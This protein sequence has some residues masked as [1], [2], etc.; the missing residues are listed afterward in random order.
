MTTEA[1]ELLKNHAW[2]GNVR[3]LRNAIDRGVVLARGTP[4]RPEHLPETVT[5]PRPMGETELEARVRDLVEKLVAQGNPGDL[6]HHVEAHWEKAL[7]RRVLELTG[8]NQVKAADLLGINRM[9]LR[10][11]MEL[12]GL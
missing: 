2:P 7:L 10:K 1:L 11:K 5:S 6:Y 3:E 8:S 9:T 4:I 12:Y